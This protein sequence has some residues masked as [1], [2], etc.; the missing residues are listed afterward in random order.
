MY[1]PLNLWYR[2]TWKSI[3]TRLNYFFYFWGGGVGHFEVL[4]LL[5]FMIRIG[6]R[7]Y[8]KQS[9]GWCYSL[10]SPR[11]LPLTA[12]SPFN[13]KLKKSYLFLPQKI[14][15]RWIIIINSDLSV[16]DR[17]SDHIRSIHQVSLIVPRSW[18]IRFSISYPIAPHSA[19]KSSRKPLRGLPLIFFPCIRPSMTLIIKPSSCRIMCPSHFFCLFLSDRLKQHPLSWGRCHTSSSE[20]LSLQDTPSNLRQHYISTASNRWMSFLTSVHVSA[21]YSGTLHTREIIIL[22]LKKVAL[23]SAESKL[24]SFAHYSSSVSTL[25]RYLKWLTCTSLL[26]FIM[27]VI[28]FVLTLLII[29]TFVFFSLILM[30]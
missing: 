20:A 30:S 19:I 16:Y 6:T 26:R 3:Q 24:T 5:N 2:S 17:F 4:S 27:T 23:A 15:G 7:G 10:G 22:S 12:S 29:V 25:S 9:A 28:D 13:N 21:P 1:L 18:A 11:H 8:Y 14:N